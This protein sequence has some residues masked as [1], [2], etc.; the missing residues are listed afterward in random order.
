[1]RNLTLVSLRNSFAL[2]LATAACSTEAPAPAPG[3]PA[4]ADSAPADTTP[5]PTVAPIADSATHDPNAQWTVGVT[6]SQR[7]VTGVALLRAVRTARHDAY[8]RI[9]FDFG[10]DPLPNY[11]IEYVDRPVRQCGSGEPVPVAGDAWLA[12]RFEPANAHTEAGQPTVTER[13]RM[14]SLPNVRELELICDYEAQVE[15]VAGVRSPEPYHVLE[16]AAPARIV[17]D[18]R[19]PRR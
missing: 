10:D 2:L 17:V 6:S 16:L 3:P 8:D 18:I 9:V 1:M 13:E 12:I 19:P 4:A 5:D 15:W 14:L 11:H 7:N